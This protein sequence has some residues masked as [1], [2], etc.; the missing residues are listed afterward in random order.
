M[1]LRRS[2]R[3]GFGLIALF[4]EASCSSLAGKRVADVHPPKAPVPGGITYLLTKPTFE[5]DV[6]ELSADK[7]ATTVYDLRVIPKA[8]ASQRFEVWL[9]SGLFVADTFSVNLGDDGRL[10]S[11]GAKSV[12]ETGKVIA[13]LAEASAAIAHTVIAPGTASARSATADAILILKRCGVNTSSAE[14]RFVSPEQD[15][16]SANPGDKPLIEAVLAGT[17]AAL[18]DRTAEWLE[19]YDDGDG[20]LPEPMSKEIAD[21]YRARDT[22]REVVR[23][24]SG[25]SPTAKAPKAPADRIRDHYTEQKKLLDSKLADLLTSSPNGNPPPAV[26]ADFD[27]AL[28]NYNNLV[29]LALDADERM[30]GGALAARRRN[31]LR[32]L[33]SSLQTG[34]TDGLGT[35]YEQLRKELAEVDRIMREVFSP[36]KASV[37]LATV[38]ASQTTQTY[39][40]V[41]TLQ[42]PRGNK[43][44]ARKR[45]LDDATL[46]ASA[47]V[48][49]AAIPAVVVS[50]PLG[51]TSEK[52]L[53]PINEP[54]S[55]LTEDRTAAPKT[56]STGGWH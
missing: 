13:A 25:G 36:P 6:K 18:A 43:P 49:Y 32:F 50:Q 48:E 11:V 24:L 40:N 10:V 45:K 29:R 20:Q 46:L 22:L 30:G 12:D 42:V 26:R 33:E 47:L 35:T 15:A 27:A 54:K 53:G 9:N 41:L 4:G 3:L 37:G 2:L 56:E 16:N 38:L 23:A 7:A 17:D 14:A 44:A 51:L 1:K 31:L 21:C 34:H 55:D 52:Q 19:A 39:R 28:S 5:I 8:D